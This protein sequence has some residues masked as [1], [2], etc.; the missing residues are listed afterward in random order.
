MSSPD[1]KSATKTFFKKNLVD[2]VI[3]ANKKIKRGALDKY[4]SYIKEAL[5]FSNKLSIFDNLCETDDTD[6]LINPAYI[7]VTI[8]PEGDP[9]Q[10][11]VICTTIPLTPPDISFIFNT[12]RQ[13]KMIQTNSYPFRA[14]AVELVGEDSRLF[15]RLITGEPIQGSV[16]EI[17]DG[18]TTLPESVLNGT[19]QPIKLKS[20]SN[21]FSKIEE[22]IINDVHGV[23]EVD[24]TLLT[25][26]RRIYMNNTKINLDSDSEDVNQRNRFESLLVYD[27]INND[28][29]LIEWKGNALTNDLIGTF[30]NG[31]KSVV[32]TSTNNGRIIS[33]FDQFDEFQQIIGE[34]DDGIINDV[35]DL[36]RDNNMS[37]EIRK[38]S[39]K[40]E[41][42]RNDN[43]Y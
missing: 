7:D 20:E 13:I 9:S 37:I 31:V 2:K 23:G 43:A 4:R 14:E 25:G 19:E 28:N 40:C 27:W 17:L 26:L 42:N 30:L 22:I 1:Y 35:I 34:G 36:E 29:T 21:E 38:F 5:E 32:G 8:T 15:W 24:T 39:L 3:S 41:F 16:L 33:L 6:E 18:D 10:T 12:D 11:E